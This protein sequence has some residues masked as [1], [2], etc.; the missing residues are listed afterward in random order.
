[1]AKD[2]FNLCLKCTSH[3]PLDRP[4]DMN[5]VYVDLNLLCRRARGE[6]M[7]GVSYGRSGSDHYGDIPILKSGYWSPGSK[8]LPN[9][10]T[11]GDGG[12]IGV[13]NSERL[14]V[15]SEYMR[16]E[17]SKMKMVEEFASW[18][19]MG[20]WHDLRNEAGCV[21]WYEMEVDSGRAEA[22]AGLARLHIQ[23]GKKL[24]GVEQAKHYLSAIE[25]LK[26]AI[27]KGSICARNILGE[28][29]KAGVGVPIDK[30]RA[31]ELWKES[32]DMGDAHAPKLVGDWLVS[33][34]GGREW[35]RGASFYE[36][37]IGR[38]TNAGAMFNLGCL[39]AVGQPGV[40]KNVEK[41]RELLERAHKRG[42]K[43]AGVELKKLPKS[44]KRFANFR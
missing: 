1:M 7:S 19:A 44:S 43:G 14:Y 18:V 34:D 39:Y 38:G 17:D 11:D 41:A 3:D 2:F 28:C 32:T 29:N 24:T 5:D 15:G 13:L 40:E 10:L 26:T 30:K 20:G 23:R 35:E 16:S 21:E 22:A 31:M 37:A 12:S 25:L 4:K 42:H 27:R 8:S 33:R 6:S 9:R 36:M